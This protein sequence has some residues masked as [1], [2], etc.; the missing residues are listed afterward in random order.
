MLA[1]QGLRGDPGEPGLP[2]AQGPAG[3]PVWTN[4]QS[5]MNDGIIL[6]SDQ[7]AFVVC[8]QGTPGVPGLSGNKVSQLI[9]HQGT[10]HRHLMIMCYCYRVR[11]VPVQ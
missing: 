9:F 11:R 10:F 5:S 2:G 8:L 7:L 3:L 4:F 1:F 6:K